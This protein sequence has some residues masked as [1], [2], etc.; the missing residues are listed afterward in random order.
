MALT[1]IGTLIDGTQV[2]QVTG[3]VSVIVKP[4]ASTALSQVPST[5]T[6]VALLAADPARKGVTLFN[7]G[8]KT[9]YVAMSLTASITQYSFK[10]PGDSF[11]DLTTVSYTGPI[12]AVW[13]GS[14][15]TMQVTSITT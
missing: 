14:G 2:T 9:A 4:A 6:S 8:N 10:M 11:F 13:V 7:E 15:A 12:S 3:D 1:I 5:T